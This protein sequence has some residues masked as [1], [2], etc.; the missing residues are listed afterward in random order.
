[1]KIIKEKILKL[2]NTE[3]YNQAMICEDIIID[4]EHSNDE[5][6]MFIRIQSWDLSKKHIDL[7]NLLNKRVRITIEVLD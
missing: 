1:M 7:N 4:T 3:D 6:G 2:E 5:N